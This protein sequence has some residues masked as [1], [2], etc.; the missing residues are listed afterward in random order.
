M[1]FVIALAWLYFLQENER[2]GFAIPDE[3]LVR[4]FLW[5]RIKLSV[6]LVFL[7]VLWPI[8]LPMIISD[9]LDGKQ[10][11]RERHVQDHV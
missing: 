11:R 9:I 8:T 6:A 5:E 1:Y 10:R 4:R 7:A 3:V 2:Y